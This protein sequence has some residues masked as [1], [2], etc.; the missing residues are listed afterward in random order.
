MPCTY[1]SHNAFPW[2]ILFLLIS[3]QSL[4]RL[5][6]GLNTL[7]IPQAFSTGHFGQVAGSPIFLKPN[8]Q[9]GSKLHDSLVLHFISS[10]S[11]VRF[12]VHG[13]EDS[14]PS[15]WTGLITSL[16]PFLLKLSLKH[17]FPFHS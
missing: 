17:K 10:F 5:L 11:Y 14:S 6:I 15:L 13:P 9:D 1:N 12:R 7:R 8:S 2:H 4:T 16:N 3:T